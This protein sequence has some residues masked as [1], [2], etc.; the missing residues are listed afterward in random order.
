MDI[1]PVRRAIILAASYPPR[2]Y[3]SKADSHEIAA[4]VKALAGATFQRDWTLVFGGHPAVSPLIL[5]V[6]R[7]YGTKDR[8]VIYQSDYFEDHISPATRALT[9]EQFGEIRFVPHAPDEPAPA[10]SDPV[11][12]TKCP[13]SLTAMRERMVHHPGVSALVLIGGDTGLRQEL[14][15]FAKAHP[16]LPI[17]P[18]GAPGG[19]AHELASEARGFRMPEDLLIAL[20]DS[21]NY[22]TLFTRVMQYLALL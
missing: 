6:A 19:I 14:D 1:E 9:E 4:A 21:R 2:E 7:E 15:L 13:K 20:P 22:L 17:I 10:P 12:A 18:L 11:D 3:K 8:V 16:N 5:M